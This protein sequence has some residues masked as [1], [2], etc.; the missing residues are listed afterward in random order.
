MTSESSVPL[1]GKV[2]LVSGASAGIGEAVAAALGRAGAS[3]FGFARGAE[4]LA[5]A[6][7]GWKAAGIRARTAPADVSREED[8]DRVVAACLEAFGRIDILVNN[9]GIA[10]VH[11]VDG[12]PVDAWDRTIAVNLRGPFLLTRMVLPHFLRQGSGDVVNISS[13]AGQEPFAEMSAYCASKFGL[14]G[15]SQALAHEVRK[16][17]VRVIA[18]CPGAVA[19]SVWDGLDAGLD[20]GRML[21]PEDVARV[22]VDLLLLPRRAVVDRI[23][24][25]PPEGIL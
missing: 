16:R 6:E 21:Q 2:A 24:L 12:H 25:T 3:V 15:F 4:R 9:A 18:V 19:T 23:V 17:G 20:R 11:A 22:I 1:T 14:L 8:V 10:A 5:R 13:V 7:A